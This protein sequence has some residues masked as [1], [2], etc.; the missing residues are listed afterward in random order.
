MFANFI[1]QKTGEL[2]QVKIGISWT[3]FL[4]GQTLG[5]PFFI[6]KM[7]FLGIIMIFWWLFLQIGINTFGF[8]GEA[9]YVAIIAMLIVS[10]VIAFYFL[11]Q[12]NKMTAKY[13]LEQGFR[14]KSDNEFVKQQVK[15]IWKFDDNVF[16]DNNSNE[17]K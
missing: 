10:F 16:L 1:N 4:F 14:I 6:R 13:Y 3:L 5:I 2:R 12:G 7:H 9:G 8:L 11:F 15:I 17:E